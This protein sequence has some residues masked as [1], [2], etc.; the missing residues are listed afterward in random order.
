M[1]GL[2]AATRSRRGPPGPARLSAAALGFLADLEDRGRAP[3]TL[4]AYRRDLVAYERFL[5]GRGLT[6][7]RAGEDDV[8]AYLGAMEAAGSRP[9]SV[10]RALVALRSLHRWCGNDAA[11]AVDAPEPAAPEPAVLTEAEAEALV[12]STAGTGA[13]A[14][15]DR[16]LLELLYAT[17]AR[18]SEI[19]GLGVGDVVG[20]GDVDGGG[21]ARLGGR[22]PRVVP[23][24]RPAADAVAAWL[25][26]RGRREMAGALG[27][28]TRE[29]VPLFVNQRGG[30]LSRQW[31]WEVV[32]VAGERAGLA[33]R[34]GPHVLRHSFAA[35]LTARGATPAAVQQLLVGQP[36]LLDVDELVEGYRRW[37]PRSG[38]RPL[39]VPPPSQ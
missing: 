4:A 14:R 1:P 39:P 11:R 21:L 27:A 22:N 9:A 24:G 13:R 5:A 19:V 8:A 29:D 33:G 25:A 2:S 35:H 30:R 26:P 37:H 38:G 15:R 18:I 20:G 7:D 12:E 6:V 31:G 10:A 32:R 17:G 3:N 16:A 28:G 34:L 23:V 36:S